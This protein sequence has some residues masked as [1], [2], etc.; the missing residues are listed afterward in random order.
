VLKP[1]RP[2]PLPE[3]QRITVTIHDSAEGRRQGFGLVPWTGS[4]EDLDYLIEDIE[5][6]PHEGPCR[7]VAVTRNCGLMG[8]TVA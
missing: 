2:L 6:D 5:N 4:L 3:K 7:A 1:S 8:T